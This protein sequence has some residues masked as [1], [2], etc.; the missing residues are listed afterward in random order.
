MRPF[1]ALWY[2]GLQLVCRTHLA[3]WQ[4]KREITNMLIIHSYIYRKAPAGANTVITIK[5]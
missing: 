3:S 2:R 1:L 5:L 4:R